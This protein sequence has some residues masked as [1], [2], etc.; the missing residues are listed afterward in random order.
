MNIKLELKQPEDKP[1]DV[2]AEQKPAPAPE[3][4]NTGESK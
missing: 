1:A 4:S 2:V 3:V